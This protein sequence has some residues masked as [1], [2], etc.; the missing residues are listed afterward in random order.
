MLVCTQA[1]RQAN[2]KFVYAT[3][4]LRKPS[5]RSS[6]NA[7]SDTQTLLGAISYIENLIQSGSNTQTIINNTISYIT[8]SIGQLN[9]S[10]G[11]L[12]NNLNAA[13]SVDSTVLGD[14]QAVVSEAIN[15]NGLVAEVAIAGQFSTES[16]ITTAI[17]A[18]EVSAGGL[19]TQVNSLSSL[20]ATNGSTI[21]QL[22][23]IV[24]SLQSSVG[25][26]ST[27]LSGVSTQLAQ[28]GLIVG[29]LADA[30]Q[31]TSNQ[32]AQLTD[33]VTADVATLTSSIQNG[34]TGL[35]ASIAS[36]AAQEAADVSS[37][38]N[39][40]NAAVAANTSTNTQL[41]ELASLV[42]HISRHTSS[43]MTTLSLS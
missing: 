41:S 32:L 29:T 2:Q 22:Q 6:L 4:G 23:T 43:I 3:S 17:S 31:N 13:S 28:V 24:S 37:L 15:L 34:L 21:Q 16:G 26:L 8:S 38:Q 36:L 5:H 14:V 39:Q 33:Q 25:D 12:V 42:L 19:M 1:H 9:G 27:Q 30:V 35:S 20:A 40:I 18:L 7:M 11:T 10:V